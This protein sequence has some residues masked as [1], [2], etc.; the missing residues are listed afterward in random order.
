MFGVE[1]GGGLVGIAPNRLYGQERQELCFYRR[2]DRCHKH[3][4]LQITQGD[5]EIVLMHLEAVQ[6]RIALLRSGAVS[7]TPPEGR[8]RDAKPSCIQLLKIVKSLRVNP[9]PLKSPSEPYV[10]RSGLHLLLDLICGDPFDVAAF[11]GQ[12]TGPYVQNLQCANGGE[13]QRGECH[14]AQKTALPR[15]R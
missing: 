15:S 12:S 5:V 9:C 6:M 2:R 1:G 4:P 3:V 10:T 14:E 8:Q 7:Q 11:E 13:D